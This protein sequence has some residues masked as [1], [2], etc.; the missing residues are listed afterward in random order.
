MVPLFRDITYTMPPYIS[1]DDD[2]VAIRT[3]IGNA[4]KSPDF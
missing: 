3:A 2:L 4:T 1:T